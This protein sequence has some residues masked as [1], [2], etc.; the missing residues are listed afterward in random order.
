[1]IADTGPGAKS[2]A[3]TKIIERIAKHSDRW[4]LE[5]ELNHRIAEVYNI[6]WGSA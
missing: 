6:I 4:D 3:S 2:R 1:V 5:K